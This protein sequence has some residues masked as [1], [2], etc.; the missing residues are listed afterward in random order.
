MKKERQSANRYLEEISV[1]IDEDTG[2]RKMS[3]VVAGGITGRNFVEAFQNTDGRSYTFQCQCMGFGTWQ[4]CR[5][6]EAMKKLFNIVEENR[7]DILQIL[8]R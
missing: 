8:M 4:K 2:I 5:H 7:N 6:V 3:L 1:S